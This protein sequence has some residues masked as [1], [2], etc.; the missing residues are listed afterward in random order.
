MVTFRS[1][2]PSFFGAAW[3]IAMVL[4]LVA[5]ASAA[6][7]LTFQ[8]NDSGDLP[9]AVVDG[10]CEVEQGTGICTLRAALDEINAT[11]SGMHY[12][13]ID[14][15]TIVPAPFTGSGFRVQPGVRVTLI[16]AGALRTT[17]DHF[18]ILVSQ[19]A[20][21]VMHGL[22]VINGPEGEFGGAVDNYGL[23]YLN[24]TTFTGNV[25]GHVLAPPPGSGG[26]IF[27]HASGQLVI[28]TSTFSA[29]ISRGSGGAIHND[30]WLGVWNSTFSLNHAFFGGG[31][32]I[33]N[34]GTAYVD[35]STFSAN[36]S[37]G[38]GGGAIQNRGQLTVTNSTLAENNGPT[39]LNSGATLQNAP[40]GTATVF[41]SLV[42]ATPAF[43]CDGEIQ[44][45]GFN[46]SNDDSCGF[47]ARGDQQD[48]D[49]LLGPLADNGGPTQTHALL[50]G[51]PAIDQG[52]CTGLDQRGVRRP[53]NIPHVP[54]AGNHC[55]IGAYEVQRS[56]LP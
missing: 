51:S 25:A 50:A 56:E 10:V 46:L 5:Q 16:G 11:G 44:S 38:S 41:N 32:A 36:R 48:S 7:A 31:G 12:V 6:N 39:F 55:D 28:S 54:N 19:D 22:S 40:G 3:I 17:I 33:V 27:N 43:N 42:Y 20:T 8:V 53:V 24:N 13:L 4:A 47:V 18:T 29:N 30:G 35:T 34:F 23:M 14:Q 1:L 26:A 52:W 21:L 37:A 15:R 2:R 45:L 9:D 49:P